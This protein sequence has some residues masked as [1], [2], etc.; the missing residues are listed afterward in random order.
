MSF[1]TIFETWVALGVVLGVPGGLLGHSWVVLGAILGQ[2][3]EALGAPLG[4]SLVLL[5][6]LGALLGDFGRL[7]IL[8][9]SAGIE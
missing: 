1:P 3:W 8:F 5:R 2:F 4:R 6:R 9:G 7:L